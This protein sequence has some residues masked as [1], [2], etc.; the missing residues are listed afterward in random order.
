ML[1]RINKVSANKVWSGSG[2]I[3]KR[4]RRIGFIACFGDA[5][6]SGLFGDIV[7]E[8]RGDFALLPMILE[9]QSIST[10]EE[11]HAFKHF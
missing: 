6:A 5:E 7:N 10:M 9:V 8:Q 11:F 2:S 1:R 3:P 4:G